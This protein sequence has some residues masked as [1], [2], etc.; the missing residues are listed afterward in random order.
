M[1]LIK[2]YFSSPLWFKATKSNLCLH[3]VENVPSM[4]AVF[5]CLIYDGKRGEGVMTKPSRILQVSGRNGIYHLTSP[6]I[7]LSVSVTWLYIMT[8]KF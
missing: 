4:V 6:H 3:L 8:K 7:L 2:R 5:I 1:S